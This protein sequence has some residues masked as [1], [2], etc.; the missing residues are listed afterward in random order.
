MIPNRRWSEGAARAL[1]AALALAEEP[2]SPRWFKGNTHT[3]T[4]THTTNS[5][6][7]S[8]PAVA[9]RWYQ[10]HGYDFLVLSDHNHLTS[11][12]SFPYERKDGL[13]LIQGEEVT[14]HYRRSE[15]DA[16]HPI[17]VNALN[18][19]AVIEPWN[20]REAVETLQRN[21]GRVRAAGAVGRSRT[22]P[23]E[24]PGCSRSSR[25][26]LDRRGSDGLAGQPGGR[27]MARPSRRTPSRSRSGSSLEK[28]SRIV[29]APPPST[30]K[31]PPA[32]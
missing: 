20:G 4:H 18:L 11:E 23:E 31:A 17:H 32:T 30:K 22:R 3:H 7:D 2:A 27:R 29:L 19:K 12:G 15:G 8:S 5:D 10:D 21:V 14:A 16:R 24:R 25:P 9:T 13:I 28:F 6:G 1:A 26:A